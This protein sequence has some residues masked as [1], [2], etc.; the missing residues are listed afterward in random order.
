[1]I[2]FGLTSIVGGL[3]LGAFNA[4]VDA[5]APGVEAIQPIGG[6]SRTEYLQAANRATDCGLVD[7][8]RSRAARAEH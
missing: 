8:L 5:A 7:A 4:M 2:D 1:L 3:G 6:M